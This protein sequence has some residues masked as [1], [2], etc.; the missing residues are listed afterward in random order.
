MVAL[1]LMLAA[2][3]QA[4]VEIYGVKASD[5]VPAFIDY[6]LNCTADVTIQILPS[7]ANGNPT[8]A[9]IKTVT[10]VGQSKGFHRYIWL[11]TKDDNSI[12]PLGAYYVAELS[13][14]S[15]QASWDAI[16]G[17]YLNS[18]WT[19]EY[20]FTWP[21][22]SVGDSE[23]FYGVGINTN[24]NSP[25]YG[26]IYVSHKVQKDV[27]M[28]G[29][30]GMYLGKFKD[31]GVEWGVSAPWDVSVADDG[32]VYVCD[33]SSMFI[34]C[35]DG[36]GNYVSMSPTTTN[37]RA[38]FARTR[39]DGSTDIVFSGS[40]A[41]KKIN[42]AADHTTWQASPFGG[43]TLFTPASTNAETFGM[44]AN[45]DVTTVY[46]ACVAGGDNG[47]SK[48]DLVGGTWQRDA[49]FTRG[50]SG[51]ADVSLV[52]A[53]TDYLWITRMAGFA[54][55]NTATTQNERSR[56]LYKTNAATNAQISSD[57]NYITWGLMN[58]PDAV[59][60]LAI[61]FG[62]STATWAQYYWGLFAEPGTYTC[63]T[64]RTTAFFLPT[65][66]APVVVPDSAV[67]TPDATIAANGS[68]SAS[69]SF[70][71]MDVN[72]WADI[73]SAT[74]D[75]RPLGGGIVPC[76]ITQDTSD[77]TGMTAIAT[78]TGITAAVGAR[79]TTSYG[80]EPH[81]L[82]AVVTDST[83]G[84]N[85]DPDEVQL[86]V[87]GDPVLFKASIKHRRVTSW[88][89]EGAQIKAVGGGIPTATDPR[90]KG[91]FTYY[92]A[93]ATTTGAASVELSAGTYQISA[94]KLGFG[95]E[96]PIN[97][98]IPYGGST[99]ALYL[100]PLTIAEARAMGDG[101]KINVEGV[102]FAQPQGFA[103]TAA[104]GLASRLDTIVKR[105]QWYVC[106]PNN[107]SEGM[108]FMVTAPSDSFPLQWDD[109]YL[110]DM[111]GNSLYIGKRP[112]EGETTMITGIL[113]C[114][115]GHERRV[116]IQNAD[117]ESHMPNE[118]NGY[119]NQVNRI[120]LNRGN[121]GGLPTAQVVGI[122]DFAHPITAGFGP[123]WGKFLKTTGATVVAYQADGLEDGVAAPPTTDPVPYLTIAD[124]AG[125]TAQ[126][127]IDMP[128]SLGNPA[129]PQIGSTYTFQ[130]AGGRRVRY[131]AGCIRVRGAADMIKE[132]DAPAAPDTLSVVRT[133]SDGEAANVKG[134]V[135][136]KIGNST[137][138]EA[139]D[140]SVGI[141]VN[142]NYSW[143]A[144][145]D[146]VQ[147]VGTFA[148]SDDN[149]M[150]IN[151]T[152]PMWALSKGNSVAALD[153]RSREI[154]GVTAGTTPG[155]DN[156]RGALNV[157]LKVHFFGMV[158]A[159]GSNYYYLWDGAN[160]ADQPVSDGSGNIGVYIEAAPPAG[161]VPWQDW[162]EVEGV[163]GT[164]NDFVP[165]V[166]IPTII[167]ITATKVTEFEEIT[168]P[169]GVALTSKWNLMSLPAAPAAISDGDEWSA[170]AWEPY[171]VLAPDQIPDYID[172][173]MYRWENCQRSLVA[174]DMWSEIGS[175]GPFGGMLLGDGYWVQ[176]DEDWPV[177]YTGKRSTLDQWIGVCESGWMIIGHPKERDVP[178]ADVWVHDGSSIQ[179]MT[180]AVLTNGLIDC[181]GYWW[182]NQT[183]ALIDI[184]IPDCW[185]TSDTL[186]GWHGYWLQ[187]YQGDISLIIPN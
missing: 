177:S 131:G 4:A 59:G 90:A 9:A 99:V 24:P 120:F 53:D 147:V 149:E 158:T 34:H 140:R 80:Q 160:R 110:E 138:I 103:P 98:V 126:I 73:T 121:I 85:S 144:V 181:V 23:G 68:D 170:K 21:L 135:T 96:A 109:E 114:P 27:F 65:T 93:P 63:S 29:P 5:K 153:M 82:E 175:H 41:I 33:R 117:I 20:D 95:S 178:L 8:G 14:T 139:A 52:D 127:A 100:R 74:L 107:P 72:G 163:V 94:T 42:V 44:W 164:E 136:A 64:K 48:W 2:C 173:R 116:L 182:D 118:N 185:S 161:V 49:N 40:G 17:L 165:G 43:T 154:G 133:A 186:Q 22:P 7:D 25:Y 152:K 91:P 166:T 71:V 134:I 60:N 79:C 184:G 137:W 75:L 19:H 129:I 35:F 148:L 76:T 84:S 124:V 128:A 1:V 61:T 145:G 156:G 89:M 111:F 187:A 123:A 69:V 155:V 58:Q 45:A 88:A 174:Y 101:T 125:N 38:I 179:T 37:H 159:V 102:C 15:N 176:L 146:E 18:D 171:M 66:P 12:A 54:N 56:A 83:G 11:A 172:S 28:Y 92:S 87:T 115:G 16:T 106:D 108:L 162:V 6:T 169:A 47:V 119:T 55:D 26:R 36:D 86:D 46:Q 130:G 67:W 50:I 39:A 10:F 113:D 105:N 132:S 13:A 168:S 97:Q 77:P 51:S 142:K 167:P 141:R 157:G 70:K 151:P 143:I 31:D 32:Y 183:Q 112:A 78:K 180:D 104:N 62:K 57:Y 81:L 30:D 150:T 122:T 3:S